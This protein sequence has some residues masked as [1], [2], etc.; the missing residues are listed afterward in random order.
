MSGTPGACRLARRVPGSAGE[1]LPDHEER[2]ARGENPRCLGQGAKL[3]MVHGGLHI[4]L[5]IAKIRLR[6]VCEP[7][8]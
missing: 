3:T 1:K 6:V 8:L 4:G 5:I 7:C 2:P